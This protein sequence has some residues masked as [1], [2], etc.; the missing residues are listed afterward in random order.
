[1]NYVKFEEIVSLFETAKDKEDNLLNMHYLS[2]KQNDQLFSHS[3]NDYD[4]PSDIRSISKTVLTITACIVMD[5]AKKGLYPNFNEKTFIFPIIKDRVNLTN[6]DNLDRLNKIKLK[7]LLNHTVGY[8]KVILMRDDIKDIDPYTYLD[9][10]INH[11]L[12][13]NPGDYYLYSNAGFYLL[14]VVLQ[15]FIQQDLLD[16]IDIH[17][18]QKL[19]ITNYK[20]EKYGNY[21]AGATRLF[22]YPNDLIK[23]GDVLLNKGIY[24]NKEI[25]AT[26]SF[27]KIVE[28]TQLTPE[29][30]TPTAVFRRYGYGS[31]IWLAKDNI[32]FGHG[33][34][35][36]TLAMIPDKR[37]IIV[38][39]ASQQDVKKLEMLINKIIID[40][41]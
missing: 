13:F 12:V 40:Y 33:T 39:L 25:I 24:K 1:M 20:W 4:Q 32:Y 11:S 38:T 19:N 28:I 5:M 8:D 23:I 15:E 22:M 14:S 31:G 36:Q 34:D 26:E 16:F 41:I 30:D 21:L 9:Y 6:L 10:V 37:T 7:H 35:G 17:L 27:E 3:F 29:V 2:I 18:F